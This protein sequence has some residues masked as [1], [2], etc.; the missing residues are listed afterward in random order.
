VKDVPVA[1]V[2][3]AIDAM[4]SGRL[5]GRNI[6]LL[7]TPQNIL[8]SLTRQA[9]RQVTGKTREIARLKHFESQQVASLQR[10]L[11]AQ[12][13]ESRQLASQL[14]DSSYHLQARLDAINAAH[15]RQEQLKAELAGKEGELTR[16][17][18]ELQA[19]KSDL[20]AKGIEIAQKTAQ[21]AATEADFAAKLQAAQADVATL[22]RIRAQLQSDLG[23]ERLT[24]EQLSA[25]LAEIATFVGDLSHRHEL[26]W[27]S[28]RAAT[29]ILLDIG[30]TLDQ[31]LRLLL[32]SRLMRLG[33]KI[34]LGQ[35]P[36][37]AEPSGDPIVATQ[38]RLRAELG[39]KADE[40]GEGLHTLADLI[41][42]AVAKAAS[43]NGGA[44]SSPS[45]APAISSDASR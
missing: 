23:R 39:R 10:D 11:A 38:Q 32:T 40:L 18:A 14:Q 42:A 2:I 8:P 6:H 27:V 20:S 22:E 28:D 34:G 30:S 12:Q 31:R 25:R 19:L 4:E 9:S 24:I 43:S 44:E 16:R 13:E 41:E 3:E 37:W 15:L 29:Q 7:P 35:T 21:F 26:Q 33:W 5:T 17:D 45:D 1:G 36:A